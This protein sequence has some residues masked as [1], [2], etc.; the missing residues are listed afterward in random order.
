MPGG[1]AARATVNLLPVKPAVKK[2]LVILLL[3]G[4]LIAGGAYWLNQRRTGAG[5]EITY[6][7][8]AVEFGSLTETVTATGPV[9]PARVYV[10]G[11]QAQGE[12]V[13]VRAD[14]NQEVEEGEILLRVDD[15]PARQKRDQAAT[16]VAAARK[17]VEQAQAKQ[18]EARVALD[19]E[20][21][22]GS[23]SSENK[24]R[25]LEAQLRTVDKA[26]EIAQDKVRLA[27]TELDGAELAVRY[28]VVRAP[29]LVP[30]GSSQAPGKQGAGVGAL[31]PDEP[32]GE[33]RKFLVLD[34]KVSL[35]QTIGPPLSG[36]LFTLAG[37][38]SVVHVEAQVAEGDI[39]KVVKGDAATFTVASGDEDVEFEGKVIDVRLLPVSDRGA[40]FYKV[41]LEAQNRRDPDTGRWALTPGLTANVDILRRRHERTW[42]MP[43]V[44]LS[45]Q[46]EEA[47]IGPEARAKLKAWQSHK[48]ADHWKPVWVVGKDKKPWPL[49][50]RVGG[51]NAA[52]K[53]G[54]RD[55]SHTEVLEWDP[56]LADRPDSAR[57]ETIPEVIIAAVAARTGLFNLPNIKF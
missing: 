29:V 47:L 43:S 4:A 39:G 8:V 12:V 22:L 5:P 55:L 38:L 40:I 13:E 10:V 50:V 25:L 53:P 21:G 6:S 33:R 16:A 17:L 56:E 31:S 57:P 54:I 41:I 18:N 11:A 23:A 24:L 1:G 7:T 45:Y 51:K 32:R 44:A 52:G 28:T 30:D 35:G 26:V 14:F 36:H 27:Q 37:E 34:R 42:K 15:R 2:L 3:M 46:P 9:Q 49:F 20:R 48:D 19:I